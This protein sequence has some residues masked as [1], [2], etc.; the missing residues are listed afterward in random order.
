MDVTVHFLVCRCVL[1]LLCHFNYDE[2]NHD[3]DT[4]NNEKIKRYTQT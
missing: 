4:Y 1:P 3:D 2:S